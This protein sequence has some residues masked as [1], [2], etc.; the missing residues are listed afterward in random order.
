MTAADAWRAIRRAARRAAFADADIYAMIAIYADDYYAIN[1]ILRAQP[2]IRRIII[3][4]MI[5]GAKRRAG[6]H[7]NALH[8]RAS[9]AT[10]G[11][12]MSRR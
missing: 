9:A 12:C 10:H 8:S 1:T 7:S 3:R 2:Q 4:I 11:N 5:S 6:C